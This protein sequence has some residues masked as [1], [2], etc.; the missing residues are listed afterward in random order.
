MTRR[1]LLLAALACTAAMWPSATLAHEGPPFPIIVDRHVGPYVASVWTDPDI[2]IGTFYVVLEAADGMAFTEPAAVRVGVAPV[3]G[4]LAEVLYDARPERVRRG[5][6]F[7]AEVAFD[8]GE[9]W[10]VRVITEGPAGGGELTS[11]VEATPD[12]TL[13]PIGLVIYSFPFVLVAVLWWRV[14]VGRRRT[15]GQSKRLPSP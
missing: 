1:A 2:G 8:R 13:G 10:H 7:V 5:A 9:Q 4:R 3:S 12:V 6:R 11:Q 14:A 15:L